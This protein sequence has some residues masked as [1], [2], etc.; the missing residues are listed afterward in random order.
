MLLGQHVPL[1]SVHP[2]EEATRYGLTV[3]FDSDVNWFAMVAVDIDEPEAVLLS[4]VAGYQVLVHTQVQRGPD[5]AVQLLQR[6]YVSQEIAELDLVRLAEYYST[7]HLTLV[8]L[9]TCPCSWI[10]WAFLFSAYL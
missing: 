7:P 3:Q 2:W 10:L 8:D 1:D 5:L 4:L 9:P 6:P